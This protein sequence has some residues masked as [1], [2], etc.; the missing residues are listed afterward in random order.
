MAII[1]SFEA[2]VARLCD[3]V[4][5]DVAAIQAGQVPD[6]AHAR[7]RAVILLDLLDSERKKK[8]V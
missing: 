7:S 4:S 3:V 6:S 1:R 2:L 8:E 5:D